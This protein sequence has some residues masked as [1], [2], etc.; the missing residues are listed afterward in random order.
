MMSRS[1][2]TGSNAGLA[3]R[4]GKSQAGLPSG[5]LMDGSSGTVSFTKAEGVQ[6]TRGKSEGGA[7]LRLGSG[8]S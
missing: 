6:T 4:T 1:T 3:S 7:T 5:T 2:N 8:S